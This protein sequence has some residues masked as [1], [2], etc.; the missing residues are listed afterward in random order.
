MVRRAE[1]AFASG[2]VLAFVCT[3]IHTWGTCTSSDGHAHPQCQCYKP[4]LDAVFTSGGTGFAPR[5]LTPEAIKPL[6]EKEAPGVVY[7]IMEVREH[8]FADSC[9]CVSMC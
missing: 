5:D 1:G 6:L 4:Q 2:R 3:S 8:D 7:R 9:L